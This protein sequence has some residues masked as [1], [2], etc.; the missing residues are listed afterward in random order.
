MEQQKQQQKLTEDEL[1]IKL[2][3][4][5]S[6]QQAVHEEEMRKKNEELLNMMKAIEEQKPDEG[7][8]F[9]KKMTTV[10]ESKQDQFDGY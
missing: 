5:K 8:G 1:Q 10:N 2:A 4:E 3:I 7:W 6:Q 9:K